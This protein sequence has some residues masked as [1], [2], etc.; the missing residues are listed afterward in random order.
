MTDQFLKRPMFRP[1]KANDP[2][3]L[4]GEKLGDI[5]GFWRWACGDLRDNTMRGLFG[6]WIVGILLGLEMDVRQNWTPYDLKQGSLTVGVKTSSWLQP[7][8]Q[9]RLRPPVF[10][11]LLTRAWDPET[12]AYAAS[13][14]YHTDWY[15]FCLQACQDGDV[16][17]ALELSQWEFYMLP[18]SAITGLG[19]KGI[20]LGQLRRLSKT[21]SAQEFQDDGRKIMGIKLG[22]RIAL[23]QGNDS[24]EPPTVATAVDQPR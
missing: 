6:E 21:L 19:M 5:A 18:R 1:I 13:A 7:W 24:V 16:W 14:A 10:N 2:V 23:L 8:A 9:A 22:D 3:Q 11:G 4:N 17:D 20:A 15:V 12:G